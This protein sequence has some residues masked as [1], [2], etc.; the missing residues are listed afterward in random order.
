MPF[1]ML[2]RV[3][4]FLAF[5]LN[6]VIGYR[7]EVIMN[8]LRN[9]FPEK[10]EEELNKI[11]IEFNKSFSDQM[12]ETLKMFTISKK[13]LGE[14]LV[15][16]TPDEITKWIEEG[17]SVVTASGHYGNW[18]YPSGFPFK[19]P[20]FDQ[21]NIIYAPLSNKFFDKKIIETRERFGC[22]MVAMRNTF[23]E[24]LRLPDSG[25]FYGFIFDQSPHK[26]MIKYDLQFL[27]QT[28]PVHLGTEQVAVKKN[29]V[30]IYVEVNRTKRGFYKVTTEILIDKPKE[31]EKYEITNLLF[32]RLEKSII[33][34]PSQWLWSHRRWKYKKGIHY[35]I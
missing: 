14:R 31:T 7:K 10:S 15:Y 33:E 16:E 30:V 26:G 6:H 27:N 29:A 25:Q 1:F 3:S 17:R 24:I 12:L 35:K 34:K 28:T 22:H 19:L 4:D 21:Y 23:R 20:G 2:Y 13:D 9:S 32:E 5:M 8:N 18:E 11:R